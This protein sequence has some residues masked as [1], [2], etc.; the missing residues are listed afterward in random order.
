MKEQPQTTEI[1]L[2]ELS[3]DSQ[4]KIILDYLLSGKTLTSF[5]NLILFK[6]WSLTQRI[7][8]LRMKGLPIMTE[9]IKAE[10]GKRLARYALKSTR[11]ESC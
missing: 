1:I 6:Y 2:S 11:N 7:F 9:M 8:D 5:E 3:K 4:S 10:S